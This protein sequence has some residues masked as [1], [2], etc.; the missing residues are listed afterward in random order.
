MKK[1]QTIYYKEGSNAYNQSVSGYGFADLFEEGFDYGGSRAFYVWEI[2]PHSYEYENRTKGINQINKYINDGYV[3]MEPDV[4]ILC[5]ETGFTHILPREITYELPLKYNGKYV[6]EIKYTINY[7]PLNAALE[8]G[9]PSFDWN[10]YPNQAGIIIYDFTR[11]AKKYKKENQEEAQENAD[12]QSGENSGSN[13]NVNAGS[14]AQGQQ[15]QQALENYNIINNPWW[16]TGG[17]DSGTGSGGVSIPIIGVEIPIYNSGETGGDVVSG[18]GSG[19]ESGNEGGD[20]GEEGGESGGE[21]GNEGPGITHTPGGK[22]GEPQVK[23]PAAANVSNEN[24]GTIIFVSVSA[25]LFMQ[26]MA[27]NSVFADAVLAKF[28]SLK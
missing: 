22:Y 13:S 19:S 24:E 3:K 5:G 9:T 12:S 10:T 20:S 18:G 6:E 4:P 16:I 21:S 1:E 28:T 26:E 23:I 27:T 25:L 17:G 2:K 14:N 15:A 7:H 11:V 8:E